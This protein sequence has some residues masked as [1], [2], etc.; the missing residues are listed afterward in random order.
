MLLQ[1]Y[2]FLPPA[3]EVHE[4]NVFTPV[5]QSF[6][7]QGGGLSAPEHAGIPPPGLEADPPKD[8][9]QPPWEQTPRSRHPRS[10]HSPSSR[11]PPGVAIPP[12]E[13][14]PLPQ[15]ML[16]DTGNKWAVLILLECILVSGNDISTP[17]IR[18]SLLTIH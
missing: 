15:C 3:N 5:C 18:A 6:C 7:S 11:H 17:S 1:I 10:R 4:G 16:G 13:D 9:R 12:G 2:L 14:L 8:Q